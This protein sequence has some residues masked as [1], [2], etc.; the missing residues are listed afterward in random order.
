MRHRW[1][2][3]RPRLESLTRCVE[4]PRPVARLSLQMAKVDIRKEERERLRGY[5][6]KEERKVK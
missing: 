3:S 2:T 4:T 1:L 5:L 6:E